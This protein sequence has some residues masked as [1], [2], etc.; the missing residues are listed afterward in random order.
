MSVAL[1]IWRL[2]SIPPVPVITGLT[3]VILAWSAAFYRLD[4]NALVMCSTVLGLWVVEL[5]LKAFVG[6]AYRPALPVTDTMAAVLAFHL[7][8]RAPTRWLEVVYVTYV[9][10]IALHTLWFLGPLQ[11]VASLHDYKV[12]LNTLYV[13]RL[14]CFAV[15]GVAYVGRWAFDLVPDHRPSLAGLARWVRH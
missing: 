13:I 6:E 12:S 10:A 14:L 7:G 2:I 5:L 8:T 4:R 11:S 9:V 15:P 3:L 1:E